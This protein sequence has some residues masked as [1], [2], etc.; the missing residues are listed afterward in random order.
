MN[1]NHFQRLQDRNNKPGRQFVCLYCG[2]TVPSEAP[3]TRHRNHCPRCLRS[4]HLDEQAGDRASPCSGI[5][6]PVAISVR[7]KEWVIIHRC[8]VCGALR[9]NRVAGDDNEM[10]L[11]SLAV[12]PMAQPPFPLDGLNTKDKER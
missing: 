1:Q 6:E 3:G 9:E 10:A 11:L 8:T 12:R 7:K 4:V 2:R 5:M